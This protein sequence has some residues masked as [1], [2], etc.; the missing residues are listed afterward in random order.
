V[1]VSIFETQA[2]S[3][4]GRN[5]EII[6]HQ[7]VGDS[8]SRRTSAAMLGPA[9]PCRDGYITLTWRG[10]QFEMT[11][12][13]LDRVDLLED[14]RFATPAAQSK[15]E[16]V[17]AFEQEVLLPW[18]M[19][20]SVHEVWDLAQG[21]HIQAGAVNNAANLLA[22][23]HVR[24]GGVWGEVDHPTAGRVT[25]PGRPRIWSETPWRLRRPAPLLGQHNE[26]VL[27]GTLGYTRQDLVRLRGQGA[28]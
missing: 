26:E 21:L 9:Y 1:D 17:R 8:G 24:G 23:S 3:M 25:Y 27:C 20:R 6:R 14:P 19:Q 11:L 7:F 5:T 22:D 18:L 12:A 15:P 2:G 13:M 16:N 4:D 28:I 10:R